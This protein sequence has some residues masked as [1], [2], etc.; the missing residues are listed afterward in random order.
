MDGLQNCIAISIIY[1]SQTWFKG[2][3]WQI[4]PNMKPYEF[5]SVSLVIL[6]NQDGSR[7]VATYALFQGKMMTY[8]CYYCGYLLVN[9]V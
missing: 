8:V 2:I 5:S 9:E 1:F 3:S 6:Y 4:H 7:H